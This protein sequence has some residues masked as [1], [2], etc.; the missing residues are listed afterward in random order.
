M[1]KKSVFWGLLISTFMSVLLFFMGLSFERLAN[2]PRELYQVYIDGKIVG[3]ITNEDELYNLIDKEQETL[4]EDYNV[5]KIYPPSNLEISKVFTYK[6]DVVKAE[7]IY[8]QIKD[9]EPFTVKG[10][11]VTIDK[12]SEEEKDITLYILKKEH[13][14]EAINSTVKMFVNEETYEAYLNGTQ[15]TEFEVGTLLEKVS[16]EEKI[17]VKESYISTEEKIYTTAEDLNR[18]IL[19][20]TDKVSGTYTIKSGDTIKSVAEAHRL[21]VIEFLIVNPEIKGENALLFPGQIVNIGLI[22]PIITVVTEQ[23]TIENQEIDFETQVKYDNNM[24]YGTTTV[25]QA[26]EKGINKVTFRIETK[27]GETT[28]ALRISSE[29]IK[30]AVDEIIVKGGFNVVY[31]GDST[32]WAWPTLKPF[33]ITSVREWRWGSWHAGIDISGTGHGS[34]IF[35]IQNGVAYS[36][37]LN[38]PSMGNY[39]YINHNNGYISIYMHLADVFVSQGQTVSKGDTIG[40][41]GNTGRSTG[42]HLHFAVYYGDRPIDTVND[43]DPLTLYQ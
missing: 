36:V 3:I 8:E 37:G 16:I 43:I 4:K 19:F 23:T 26:G 38:H 25:E 39:I 7:D 1:N 41:M 17:T 20:G 34:P 15:E 22:D 11:E 32:Y 33:V 14:D 29:E 5:D 13:L 9:K 10:Y 27:N 2:S 18:F 21:N 40:T 30:P 6:S 12:V 28:N 42:T 31:V 35:S 24:A